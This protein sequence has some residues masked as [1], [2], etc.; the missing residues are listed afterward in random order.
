MDSI[1]TT[2]RE[3]GMT[4]A[5]IEVLDQR[6]LDW[7]IAPQTEGSAG[8][9]MRACI[10]KELIL[11]P[12]E[13]VLVGLGLKVKPPEGYVS[14]LVPRSGLGYKHGIVLRNTIGIIDP[15]YRDELKAALH[16]SADYPYRVQ[17]MDRICQLLFIAYT[18]PNLTFGR[19]DETNRTGG[20]NSTGVK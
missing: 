16:N 4:E 18:I 1:Q 10:D 14:I 17:P 15:D 8:F 5:M 13:T 20:F 19:L 9:D 3:K 2:V 7:G 12:G 6:L 11:H